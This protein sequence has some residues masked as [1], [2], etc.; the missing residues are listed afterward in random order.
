MFL[1]W[2]LYISFHGLVKHLIQ[3]IFKSSILVEIALYFPINFSSSTQK[4]INLLILSSALNVLTYHLGIIK[5]NGLIVYQT[6]FQS[7]TYN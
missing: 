1:F 2:F 3:Y 7:N 4:D 6:L 5:T